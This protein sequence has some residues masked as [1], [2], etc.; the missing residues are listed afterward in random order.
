MLDLWLEQEAQIEKTAAQQFAEYA[1]K[2]AVEGAEPGAGLEPVK[3]SGQE[4]ESSNYSEEVKTPEQADKLLQR[5]L[6]GRVVDEVPKTDIQQ[7]PPRE[8]NTKSGRAD[9]PVPTVDQMKKA[10]AGVIGGG[11]AVR[12][13]LKK[14]EADK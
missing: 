13:A 4:W 6:T 7:T 10:A 8:I 11:A 1:E 3:P 12:H 14:R 5:E 2:I 9:D